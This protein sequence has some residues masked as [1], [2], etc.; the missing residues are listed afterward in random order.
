MIHVKC[1]FL[2]AVFVVCFFIANQRYWVKMISGEI[3]SRFATC[4][5]ISLHARYDDI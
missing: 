4:C 3:L 5:N 1:F 2:N